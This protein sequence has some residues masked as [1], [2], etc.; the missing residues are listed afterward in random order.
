MR[1]QHR[2]YQVIFDRT[3]DNWKVVTGRSNVVF[4]DDTRRGAVA[5]ARS[6]ARAATDNFGIDTTLR[7]KNMD[8]TISEQR[9]YTAI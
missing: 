8:G 5:A 4:R 3:A 1:K 2:L 7:V 6:R 9:S